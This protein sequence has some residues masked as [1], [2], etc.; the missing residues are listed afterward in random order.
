MN[1]DQETP[2]QRAFSFLWGCCCRRALTGCSTFNRDWK[3][4]ATAPASGIQGRWAGTWRSEVN[5]HTDQL[6]CLMTC[7]EE[8]S[9]Q[10]R[11]HAKYQ[12]IFSFG[13]TVALQV[14][15]QDGIFK[16]KGDANLGWYAG[17]AYHYEGTV[18]ATNFFATYRCKQDHGTFQMARPPP[19]N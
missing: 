18:S 15:P 1:R 16:F 6:R 2:G 13:Y 9:C 10:A 14:T 7:P 8:G 4:A 5:G 3:A 19:D 17:G 12:K 11:F